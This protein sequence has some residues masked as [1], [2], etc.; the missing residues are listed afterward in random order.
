MHPASCR[1][2]KQLSRYNHRN[3][4]HRLLNAR[5]RLRTKLLR[6]LRRIISNLI[7]VTVYVFIRKP[8]QKSGQHADPL[9]P[10]LRK[11]YSITQVT[12]LCINIQGFTAAALPAPPYPPPTL[13]IFKILLALQIFK[14]LYLP[15]QGRQA[16]VNES[17]TLMDSAGSE[18]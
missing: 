18:Y 17:G 1:C 8:R 14:I 11:T 7:T 15:G 6:T 5:R 16:A 12:V 9:L 4:A 10:Y 13:Q 3:T 2:L